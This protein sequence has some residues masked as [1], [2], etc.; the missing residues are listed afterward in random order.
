MSNAMQH[1]GFLLAE[2]DFQFACLIKIQFAIEWLIW[3]STVLSAAEKFVERCNKQTD[4][5]HGVLQK[6]S[7]LML[8]NNE[9]IRRRPSVHDAG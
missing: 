3:M 7:L 9:G 8:D 1:L 4:G 5:S 2:P 6:R